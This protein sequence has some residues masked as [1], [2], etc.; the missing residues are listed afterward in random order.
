MHFHVYDLTLQGNIPF[1][2][3]P[4]AEPAPARIDFRLDRRPRAPMEPAVWRPHWV[5][6]GGRPWLM[7][8]R[9]PDGFVL[10]VPRLLDFVISLDGRRVTGYPRPKTPRDTVRHVWLDQ[11]LPLALSVAGRIVLHASAVRT[12]RGAVAFVGGPRAGKSTLTAGLGLRGWRSMT[13]DGVMVVARRD[14]LLAVPSYP[15]VRLWHAAADRLALGGGRSV[16]HDANKERLVL[17][18]SRVAFSRGAA[19]LRRIYLLARR[20]LRAGGGVLLE[21]MSRRQATV[22]LV[23]YTFCLEADDRDRLADQF[24]QLSRQTGLVDVRRLSAPRAVSGLDRV[25]DAILADLESDR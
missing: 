3:L 14:R 1:P 4:R 13:D 6:P 8:G 7:V 23:K 19:R 5:L 25:R 18:D 10:R 21:P 12:P 2:E 11:V 17:T 16:A 22:E 15:G 20:G 9:V 24:A